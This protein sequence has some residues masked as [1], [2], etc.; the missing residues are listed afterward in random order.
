VSDIYKA[1][2]PR[3]DFTAT[4]RSILRYLNRYERDWEREVW[5]QMWE[6]EGCAPPEEGGAVMTTGRVR[7]ALGALV[8]EGLLR[9]HCR[10]GR[11]R[12]A[13]TH[14]GRESS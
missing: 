8:R 1:S 3:A 14:E 11:N 6:M 5:V 9:R 13:L 12:Y 10:G 7:S 2:V 4:K